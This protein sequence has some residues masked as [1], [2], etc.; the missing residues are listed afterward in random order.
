MTI[1]QKY[2]Q[3]FTAIEGLLIV[4]VL[5]V[6]GFGGYYV[7]HSQQTTITTAKTT[8]VSSKATTNT[9]TSSP[10]S[11]W[12]TY[13][14]SK[15]KLTFRYPTTWTVENNLTDSSNDGVQFTSK[16]D[17][18]FE[19]LIGAG[20]AVAAVDNYDGNCVQ[21][22]DSV[23]F[24]KTSAYLDLTGFANTN[25]VPPSCSPASA[26]IQAVVLS[27]S[28][29]DA[30]VSNFFLTKNIAQ[31]S[32]PSA[33]E[34]VVDIDYDAPNGNGTNSKTITEIEND[35]DYKDAKLVVDSM[36]Y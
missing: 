20:G 36:T 6:V 21:Q 32:A 13:T 27:Q 14:F 28:K 11:G 30:G 7:W 29:T 4:L 34:I 26:T 25:A 12:N 17:S 15:E 35:T 3:G 9:A 19:V 10:Y 5:A 31:P 16:T 23:T 22:A 2:Q 24:N 1:N 33:S 18:S 8:A